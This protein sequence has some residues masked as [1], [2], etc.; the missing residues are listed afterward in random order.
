VPWFWSDQGGLKLQIAG[1]SIGVDEVVLRG[2]VP[3]RKFSAYGF[4]GGRLVA[5]ESVGKPA[6]HMAA[7][8]LLAASAPVT[9]DHVRNESLDLR[10]LLPQA[11]PAV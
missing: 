11:A 1:L 7:R 6:D 3:G 10:T 4:S 2:D 8:K 9:P 5:V